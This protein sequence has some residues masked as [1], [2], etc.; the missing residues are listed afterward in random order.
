MFL[1][2]FKTTLLFLF[3]IT[4]FAGTIAVT[5]HYR[6]FKTS[7]SDETLYLVDGLIIGS[8]KEDIALFEPTDSTLWNWKVSGNGFDGSVQLFVSKERG[9]G[10]K[11]ALDGDSLKAIISTDYHNT[12]DPRL[13]SMTTGFV[14]GLFCVENFEPDCNSSFVVYSLKNSWDADVEYTGKYALEINSTSPC[15]KGHWKVKEGKLKI[16]VKV[17][18]ASIFIAVMTQNIRH[19]FRNFEL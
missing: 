8:K 10:W 15:G 4:S 14:S 19:L 9:I 3:S 16:P 6:E 7:G 11:F 17:Q 1:K 12:H 13:I 2:R 18:Y 5:E